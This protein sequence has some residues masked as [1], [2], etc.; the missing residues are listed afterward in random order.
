MPM[1]RA[2]GLE[3]LFLSA[4]VLGVTA[5]VLAAFAACGGSSPS[6][7]LTASPQVDSGPATSADSGEAPYTLDDVCE[8][9]GPI[10]CDLRKGCCSSSV[11]YDEAGC[12]SRAKRE[13][14]ADV[15]DVRAG[16]AEFHGERIP[17]CIPRFKTV[18]S[19]CVLGPEDLA[20]TA[21][22]LMGCEAFAGQLVEGAS[23][24]RTSQC[25]P[26]G[27]DEFV[28]CNDETKKCTK[29][30]L[31]AENQPCEIADSLP[32]LCDDALFCDVDFG[33]DSGKLKG[34]CKKKTALGSRCTKPL[35]CGLG[36]YC[37]KATG[38][39]VAGA[40][41][42]SA[43]TDNL[44]CASLTCTKADAGPGTCEPLESLVKVEE[45]KGP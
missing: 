20:K 42:S 36:S 34:T 26:G 2:P 3:R 35:E 31:L 17:G 12:L 38:V 25:K 5:S 40:R 29:I 30:R 27:P 6:S 41:G 43:C 18:L 19:T 9:T 33:A 23:C 10:V 14:D 37:H 13:C 24:E 11:G 28:S 39:C 32:E 8:R 16:R 45:C 1:T 15:A 44:E 21:R 22:T 4:A 7:D